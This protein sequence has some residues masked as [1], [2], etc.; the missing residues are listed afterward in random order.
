MKTKRNFSEK[1]YN[2]CLY[3]PKRLSN[4]RECN[5]P[6]TGSMKTD[7]WREY[8]RDIKEVDGL[9]F[10]EIA[11]RTNGQMSVASLQG[12]LAPGTTR[13]LNR[14][15]AR[16]IENAIFG[17]DVAHPCPFEFLDN[18]DADGKRVMEVEEELSQLRSNIGKTHEFQEKVINSIREDAEKRFYELK[19]KYEREV[20]YL[21]S[22]VEAL[23]VDN[24]RLREQMDRK[25][26]YIDRLAKKAGI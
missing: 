24:N 2:R 16:I 6:R 7:R 15:T 11:A 18:M 14:E 13:D 17:M 21:K 3:C 22:Q 23:Q 25:D 1:P 8:M 9:T 5:G 26:D 20:A 19:D 10:E 12:A 4:P